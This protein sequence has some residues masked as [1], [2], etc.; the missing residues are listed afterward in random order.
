MSMMNELLLECASYDCV[1]IS[2]NVPRWLCSS[3]LYKNAKNEN[4]LISCEFVDS[5]YIH[6]SSVINTFED[7]I[8]VTDAVDFWGVWTWPASILDYVYNDI[9]F[10]ESKNT[11]LWKQCRSTGMTFCSM[12]CDDVLSSKQGFLEA[13]LRNDLDAWLA[14]LLR[15]EK[16]PVIAW[17]NDPLCHLCEDDLNTPYDGDWC[18]GR[19]HCSYNDAKSFYK[20]IKNAESKNSNYTIDWIKSIKKNNVSV[21]NIADLVMRVHDREDDEDKRIQDEEEWNDYMNGN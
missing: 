14:Y 18:W 15:N 9:I 5:K 19:P 7:F 20:T 1:S 10:N 6:H 17:Y 4:I 11:K 16:I 3:D 12:F 8:K 21:Y 2:Q 13:I